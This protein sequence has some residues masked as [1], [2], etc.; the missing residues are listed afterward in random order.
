MRS[1]LASA[2]VRRVTGPW[3]L[4]D[5]GLRRRANLVCA[6]GAAL[7]A[8]RSGP[9]HAA[10]EPVSPREVIAGTSACPEPAAVWSALAALA[11]VDRV[12]TRLRALAGE[13]RP[14]EV[15]DLGSAFRVRAGDRTREYEDDARDC[16]NRAKLAAVFVALAADSADDPAAVK[17]AQTPPGPPP[18]V[19]LTMREPTAAPGPRRRAL[20]L[21]VG[22]D[23]RVAVGA[24]SVAPGA[25]AQL[26]WDRGRLSIA[27][28]ARGSAPAQATIGDVR[29]RQW[30]VAAQLA[31]RLGLLR[32]RPVSPFLEIGVVAALLA[33]KGDD[34]ATA[35]TG[36]GGELGIVAGGG[37]SFL[38]RAWGS[39]FVLVEVEV[40]PAPPTISALPAGDVGRTPRVWFGAAVGFRVG[41]L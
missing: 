1:R 13:A 17:L 37:I 31:A 32:D 29:V 27:A 2:G 36:L 21:E 14:V 30:R 26:A 19:T 11:V 33:E 5:V 9:A 10:G 34:L 40:D 6:V 7:L 25:L 38:R 4:P 3:R 23:A 22:A 24:S 39:P 28:G 16:A 20:H 15:T 18:P 41:L 8:F 12:E 35:R